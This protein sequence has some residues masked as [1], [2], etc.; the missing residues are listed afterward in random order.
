MGDQNPRQLC[1]KTYCRSPPLSQFNIVDDDY[2]EPMPNVCVV[3]GVDMGDCNPR[4]LCG[5]TRCLC[6]P[7]EKVASGEVD[8]DGFYVGLVQY[9]KQCEVCHRPIDKGRL[10][11]LLY[12]VNTL[13]KLESTRTPGSLRLHLEDSE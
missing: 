3:C 7:L 5:K 9:E 2:Y 6:P 10:C 4:Q 1:G 12:C 11:G 8:M 13:D